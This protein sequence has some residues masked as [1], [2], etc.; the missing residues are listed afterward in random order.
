MMHSLRD[1]M[2]PD[3]VPGQRSPLYMSA[4]SAIQSLYSSRQNGAEILAAMTQELADANLIFDT[5]QRI[6]VVLSQAM[7]V[8]T[9]SFMV[10]LDEMM[11]LDDLSPL[12]FVMESGFLC[13]VESLLSTAGA[14][15]KVL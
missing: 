11:E 12:E 4:A 7:G 15:Y 10:R 3:S 14:E 9:T 13:S 2:K 1:V 8:V 5:R 6:D